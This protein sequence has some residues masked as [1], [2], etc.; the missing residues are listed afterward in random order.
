MSTEGE[1]GAERSGGTL[2]PGPWC[3][4]WG[5]RGPPDDDC[6]MDGTLDSSLDFRAEV[7][8]SL[9]PSLVNSLLW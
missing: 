5:K 8:L 7:L 9:S 2:T 1:L 3:Q 4:I 6:A